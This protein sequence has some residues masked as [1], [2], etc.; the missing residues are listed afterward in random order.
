MM[1]I[2]CGLAKKESVRLI[3]YVGILLITHAGLGGF[4]HLDFMF[5]FFLLGYGIEKAEKSCL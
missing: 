3:G 4:C 5:P 2:V 1:C